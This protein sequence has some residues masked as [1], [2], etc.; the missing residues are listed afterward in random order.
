MAGSLVLVLVQGRGGTGV[1]AGTGEAVIAATVAEANRLILG[2][3]LAMMAKKI[4]LGM[5][6]SAVSRPDKVLV[7]AIE[8]LSQLGGTDRQQGSRVGEGGGLV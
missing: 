8:G 2:S 6:A 5:R 3:V 7:Q 4:A 1:G